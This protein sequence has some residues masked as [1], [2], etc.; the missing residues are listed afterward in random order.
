MSMTDD[1][2]EYRI[3]GLVPGR[4]YLSA[5]CRMQNM[6]AMGAQD[7]H[8]W[9]AIVAGTPTGAADEDY[10]PTYYPGTNDPTGAVPIELAA[11]MQLR[12]IDVL[13][14]KTRTVRI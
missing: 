6:M 3:F 10:A 8:T 4:Y 11:G 13:L 9:Q 14:R 2:G 12:S 1:L 7:L 5:T